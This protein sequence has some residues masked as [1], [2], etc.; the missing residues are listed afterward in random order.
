MEDPDGQFYTPE[1]VMKHN[2]EDDCWTVYQGKIYDVTDYLDYHPGGK[3]RLMLGA[4]NNC[5]PFVLKYHPWVNI[6]FIAKK[7]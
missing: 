7:F 3:H 1:E 6:H 4:G 5:E 2:R